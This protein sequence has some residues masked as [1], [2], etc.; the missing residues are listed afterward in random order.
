MNI[1]GIAQLAGVSR[2]TVSRYLNNGYVSKEKRELIA[3]AIEETG[4]VP[5]QEA[6]QLRTGKSKLV[7]VIIP[8]INSESVSRMISGITDVLN[9]SG[10]QVLLANTDNDERAEVKYLRLF[11]KRTRVDGVI[12]IATI[13]TD[14][15]RKA[16]DSLNVPLVLL[17]QQ[18]EGTACV[19]HDDY[20]AV[21]DMTRTVLKTSKHPGYIGVTERDVAAGR[22]RHQGFLDACAQVGRPVRSEAQETASFN[23]DS[24]YFACERLMEAAPDTDAIVCATDYIAFGAIACLRE[25][26]HRVPEDVQVT[27]VGD[28][29]LS[30]V[31]TPSLST[32]HLYYRTSG[33]EAARMLISALDESDDGPRARELKMGYEIHLRNSTR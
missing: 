10:R 19:F 28:S 18:V 32:A 25:Y 29:D 5:S 26:G 11:S 30:R 27:G 2:A 22:M 4:Y 21:R 33:Q 1:N 16:I 3:K 24:G 13:L 20:R 14:A 7:C 15:H 8:K 23:M 31:T 6:R 12:L 9:A 17:G